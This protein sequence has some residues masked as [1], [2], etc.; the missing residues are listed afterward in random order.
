MTGIGLAL[1]E[2]MAE[3][4]KII[5][6]IR[7]N[8]DEPLGAPHFDAEATQTAQRVVPLSDEEARLLR[9]GYAMRAQ[10]PFW[11]RPAVIALVVLVAAG[12]GVAAGFA[13]GMYRNR[14]AAQTPVVNV[15]PSP[16]EST[17]QIAEQPTP[18][19]SPQAHT[20]V[21]EKP[22]ESPTPAEPKTEERAPTARNETKNSNDEETPPATSDK[23][24][25][26]KDEN[27]NAASDD[28][29]AERERRREARRAERRREQDEENPIDVPRQMERARQ[30]VNRIREIFEGKQP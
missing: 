26:G 2:E 20:S 23:K 29:Q 16:T 7:Q 14:N 13:I 5:I 10:K 24:R 9:Q 15:Q 22:S 25:N 19:P 11:K 1:N 8:P 27:D 30:Q 28:K 21:P 12:I 18:V 3:R 17:N 4:R 6:P